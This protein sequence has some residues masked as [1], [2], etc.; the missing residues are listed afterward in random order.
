MTWTLYLTSLLGRWRPENGLN[1]QIYMLERD[2]SPTGARER[3]GG[4]E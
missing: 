4:H 2:K 1:I 3:P